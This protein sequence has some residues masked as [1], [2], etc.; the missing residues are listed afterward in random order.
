MTGT[1][2]LTP[3]AVSELILPTLL[4]A[5]SGRSIR[6]GRSPYVGKLGQ[7][8]ASRGFSLSDP[9]IDARFLNSADSDREGLPCRNTAL[10]TD[11][12]LNTFLYDSYEARRAG[13]AS[14]GHAVGGATSLPSVGIHNLSVDPGSETTASL[15]GS[16]DRCLLV[17]R[18][19]GS[20]NPVTGDF[21]GVAKGAW[22]IEDG[23]RRP[24]REVQISGNVFELLNRISG[25]SSETRIMEGTSSIPSMRFED[26]IVTAG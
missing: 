1:V 10:I 8:I 6:L 5:I 4:G 11:G 3:E 23:E 18:W 15:A 22:M 26:V 12:V 13:V 7:R 9:A 17:T 20:S 24:V 14:T 16:I 2:I 25:I 21:S 19:S